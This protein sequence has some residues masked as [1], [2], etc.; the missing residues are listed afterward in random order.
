MFLKLRLPGKSTKRKHMAPENSTEQTTLKKH[1]KNLL[2]A[3]PAGITAVD[4]HCHLDMAAYDSDRDQVIA[5]AV[6]NGVGRILTIGIDLASSTKAVNLADRYPAVYAAIGVHPHNATSIDDNC[7]Q[8]LKVLAGH[9]KVVAY[10]EI[11]LDFVKKYS[12]V[13]K[14]MTQFRKQIHIAKELRLPLIIHDRGAHL[15][16]MRILRDESPFPNGGVMHCFSGDAELAAEVIDLGLHISVPG[17]VTYKNGT[18]L[19]EVVRRV[20]LDG[21][22]IETDGPFLTPVPERGKRNRPALVLHT[23]RK[24]AELKAISLAEVVRR[25]TM[26]AEALFSFA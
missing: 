13:Q 17:I 25:T 7:Y 5:E 18:M 3:L 24:I 12:P 20:A 21:I 14:Q 15:E 11:G 19:Q 16:T 1:N 10:G 6:H 2:P 8:L 22:L 23:A 9:P 4:T 26:N